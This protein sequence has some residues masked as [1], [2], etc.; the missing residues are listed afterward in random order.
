MPR[1]SALSLA[2]VAALASLVLFSGC[3]GGS[4]SSGGGS[5]SSSVLVYGRGGDADSL[6]PVK[7]SSGESVTVLTNVFDTLVTYDDTPG[8]SPKEKL[9]IVPALAE[10]WTTSDDGLVWT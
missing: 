2:L 7:T 5:G 10:S 6:D 8:L 4:S 1:L 3:F 9:K